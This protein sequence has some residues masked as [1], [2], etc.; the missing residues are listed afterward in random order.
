MEALSNLLGWGKQ[1]FDWKPFFPI[2]L[3]K[4][5]FLWFVAALLITFILGAVSVYF[6]FFGPNKNSIAQTLAYEKQIIA[7]KNEGFVLDWSNSEAT[8]LSTLSEK[9]DGSS[10][11]SQTKKYVDKDQTLTFEIMVPFEDAFWSIDSTVRFEHEN[12]S[13]ISLPKLFR[14]KEYQT[15]FKRADHLVCV[16]L[17]SQTSRELSIK[18]ASR[19]EQLSDARAESLCSIVA[20][21]MDESDGARY[22]QLALGYELNKKPAPK[23]IAAKRQRTAI[24]IGIRGNRNSAIRIP[25]E[26]VVMTTSIKHVDLSSYTRSRNPLLKEFEVDWSTKVDL[27]EDQTFSGTE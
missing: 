10:L 24:L 14:T 18:A 4:A 7:L 19:N 13:A 17:A 12:G 11:I 2:F 3:Q 23:S 15:A 27:I 1:L 25:L 26:R 6:R 16:G 5:W 8:I 9:R 21:A 22:W 20:G